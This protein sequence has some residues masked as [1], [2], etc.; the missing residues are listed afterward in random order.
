MRV[1]RKED[2]EK[3]HQSSQPTERHVT[4]TIAAK[5]NT[6]EPSL[7]TVHQK[8]AGEGDIVRVPTQPSPQ[9]G[10]SAGQAQLGGGAGSSYLK[11]AGMKQTQQEA[12]VTTKQV[13]SGVCM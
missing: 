13:S 3:T 6:P 11:L 9:R 4:A 7:S 1:L 8:R 2:V 5:R 12:T 10:V